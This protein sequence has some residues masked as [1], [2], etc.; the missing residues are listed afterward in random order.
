MDIKKRNKGTLN[1]LVTLCF[2]LICGFFIV[3][4][5][6]NNNI[7][8][9]DESRNTYF[10]MRE[11][12]KEWIPHEIINYLSVVDETTW[13]KYKNS[14]NLDEYARLQIYGNKYSEFKLSNVSQYM[15]LDTQYTI[16]SEDYKVYIN[17]I[18]NLNGIKRHTVFIATIKDNKITNLVVY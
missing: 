13:N 8:K 1:I 4:I 16:G 12:S 2:I 14:N 11:K 6:L 5:G 3:S 17:M 18:L 15:I 10:D 9:L 7:K